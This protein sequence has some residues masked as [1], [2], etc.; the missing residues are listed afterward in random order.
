MGEGFGAAVS[1]APE[2]ENDMNYEVVN[3]AEEE[4]LGAATYEEMAA[5]T[6]EGMAA[7]TYEG[8]DAAGYEGMG[9]YDD[10][11]TKTECEDMMDRL[12]RE[13][14]EKTV[15]CRSTEETV[16]REIIKRMNAKFNRKEFVE[17]KENH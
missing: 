17:K 2:E 13:F 15:Q 10:Y 11:I 16:E 9:E 1:R 8:L 14:N 3:T 5:A 4:M 7:A 12:R 6:Y